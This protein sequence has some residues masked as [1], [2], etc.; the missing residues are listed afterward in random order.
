M[1]AADRL[2]EARDRRH[3]RPRRRH[4]RRVPHTATFAS[5]RPGPDSPGTSSTAA[6]SPGTGAGSWLLPRLIG[7]QPALRLLYSGEFITADDALAMGY[8]SAVVA[9]DDLLAAA[10]TEAERFLVGSPMS[11]RLIKALVYEGLGRDVGEHMRAHTTALA[12]SFKSDDH[13]E[14][15]ASF[16]E[17]RPANFTGR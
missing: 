4:G 1:V 13:R 6:S 16:L 2:P 8:V 11:Q 3:R 14:G 10:R 12:A 15:V 17:K 9:P 7:V 5:P